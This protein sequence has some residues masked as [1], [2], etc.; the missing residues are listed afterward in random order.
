M[1]N[2]FLTFPLFTQAGLVQK[3]LQTYLDSKNFNTMFTTMVEHLLTTRPEDPVTTMI[4][5]LFEHHPESAR[6]AKIR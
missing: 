5:Y 1:Y 4:E 3:E 2:P 6:R